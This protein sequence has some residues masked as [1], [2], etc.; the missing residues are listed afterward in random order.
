MFQKKGRIS[1]ENDDRNLGIDEVLDDAIEAGAEDVEINEDGSLIIWTE[2]SKT[3]ST[4]EAL[5]SKLELKLQSSGIIWDA[6]KDTRV[7]MDNKPAVDSLS[8]AVDYLRTNTDV[9]TVYANISQG[10]LQDEEW[11]QLESKFD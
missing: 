6:N 5:Q 11:W 1:F 4:A 7:P 2:P 3:M 10:S 9:Q 8:K